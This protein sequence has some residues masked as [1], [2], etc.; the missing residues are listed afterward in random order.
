[1]LVKVL[2]TT[3]V[4]IDAQ[5]VEIETYI[6]GTQPRFTLVGLPD[7]IVRE[8]KDRVRC[9]IENSGFSFPQREII[10][11]LAPASLPKFGSGFDLGIALT[12]LASSG[13]INKNFLDNVVCVGE[14][15]LDGQIKEAGVEVSTALMLKE[16][17]SDQIL[18]ISDSCSQKISF[19]PGI[20]AIFSNS[21]FDLVNKLNSSQNL[22]IKTSG[23]EGYNKNSSKYE[24]KFSDVVGQKI[25]KRAMEIAAAGGHN[26]LMIGPPGSG[27]TMLAERIINIM[28]EL[29]NEELY[30][31]NKIY[32]ASRTLDQGASSCLPVVERQFRTP[33]HTLSL[34]GLVGGGKQVMPGEISLAHKGVL[35]LDELPEVRRDVLEALREPLEK[36]KVSISRAQFKLSYPADFILIAAMN[37]CPCGLR[38]VESKELALQAKY[39]SRCKC[40]EAEVSRYIKKISGPLI[41]RI[42]IQIWIPQM[43]LGEINKGEEEGLQDVKMRDR[44]KET[45]IVQARRFKKNTRLN[46]QMLPSEIRKYCELDERS[47]EI[48]KNAAKKFN[49]SARAYSRI[50]KLS[51]TIADMDGE[52]KIG[53]KHTIE[54]LSYR[55][56]I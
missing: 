16:Q 47:F 49:L 46:S 30:S 27:K 24:K 1:M 6:T 35:F 38:G 10:V 45:R 4:G 7:G 51:R 48:V 3:L 56:Q 43:D 13:F 8:A 44:V 33:H 41:D 23:R 50:L 14:L 55:I 37:P 9:A 11:N 19:F 12:I 34:A 20:N 31:V 22:V 2:S 52:D 42:D 32:A 28:P 26:M 53:S 54:A 15:A 40:N 17:R 36:K 25:A 29:S 18:I 21:L 5:K 39:N